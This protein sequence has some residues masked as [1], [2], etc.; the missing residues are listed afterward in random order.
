[1][2][3]LSYDGV[4]ECSTNEEGQGLLAA[5][6]DRT[7]SFSP[8]ITFVPTIAVNDVSHPN[9]KKIFRLTLIGLLEIEPIFSFL[10]QS[11][12]SNTQSTAL[13]NF[14]SV[15]CSRIEEPKPSACNTR[16]KYY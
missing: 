4:A 13:S 7:H 2:L 15:I 5:L 3:G 10:L 8:A 1:M 16:K 6:G 11:Y 12:D 14:K 9:I